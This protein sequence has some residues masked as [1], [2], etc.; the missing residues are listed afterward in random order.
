V[1]RRHVVLPVPAAIVILVVIVLVF[2]ITVYELGGFA[3]EP[4]YATWCD[5]GQNGNR[6]YESHNGDIAVVPAD[7]TC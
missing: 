3:A 7:K 6:I 1:N 2:L 4:A 5:Q